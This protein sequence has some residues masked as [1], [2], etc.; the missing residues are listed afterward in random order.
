MLHEIR[1]I[2]MAV[3]LFCA[4]HEPAT[5]SKPLVALDAFLLDA[6]RGNPG[7]FNVVS[8]VADLNGDGLPDWIGMVQPI[9]SG[10]TEVSAKVFVLYQRKPGLFEVQASSNSFH[11]GDNARDSVDGIK[12]F[13]HDKFKI[14]FI[15]HGAYTY[16]GPNLRIFTFK[17][18]RN[19]W[20]LIG[21]D[22][23]GADEG[24]CE[25]PERTS[26]NYSMNFLTGEVIVTG[27]SKG[28]KKYMRTQRNFPVLLLNDFNAESQF[29]WAW[30]K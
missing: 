26:T 13:K 4:F 20:R 25:V 30:D 9:A 22:Y 11:Y 17:L 19:T 18:Q 14:R 16:C 15:N 8:E 1:R 10:T 6:T 5:A 24:G 2:T 28:K 12:G 27:Y 7:A 23:F 3:L 29:D 21:E